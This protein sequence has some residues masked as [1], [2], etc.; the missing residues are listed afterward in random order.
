MP[1]SLVLLFQHGVKPPPDERSHLGMLGQSPQRTF[2][3]ATVIAKL[4]RRQGVHRVLRRLDVHV[5]G[6]HGVP[7]RRLS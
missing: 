6:V 2:E 7:S 3:L 1:G 4:V 5:L